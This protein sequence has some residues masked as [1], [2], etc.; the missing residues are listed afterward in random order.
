MV[1]FLKCAQTKAALTCPDCSYSTS[2][3][4]NMK[5][6]MLKGHKTAKSN[7]AT[8]RCD[9]CRYSTKLA[10]DYEKHMKSTKHSDL[11]N[12]WMVTEAKEIQDKAYAEYLESRN[13][14]LATPASP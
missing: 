13:R 9:I 3:A 8:Y 10:S 11:V 7:Q 14:Q 6:H 12:A 5:R 4:Q 1:K 2:R